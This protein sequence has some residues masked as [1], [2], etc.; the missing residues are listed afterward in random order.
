MTVQFRNI[1][2][3]AVT[4]VAFAWT[5]VAQAVPSFA[6]KHE[7]N[8]SACHA[9]Y[10]QLNATGR[11]Y[12]ENGYRFL[13][14]EEATDALE[15]SDSLQLEKHVPI[16]GILV[17]RPYDKKDSG[18]EKIRALHEVELIV[19]GNISENWSGYFEIEAEDETGFEP[20]LAPAVLTYNHSKELNVQ[21]VYGP[22]FWADPYGILGDHF[23]LTRGHVGAIDQRFGNADAGGR[24][25]AVR[26]NVG[27]YGR[28]SD[29][30]FYNVNFSGKAADA[31][32][33]NASVVSGLFNAEITDDIMVGVFTMNGDDEA[34]NRDFDRSGVQFQVDLTDLRIQGL[35]IAATDDRD[36]A[37]PRGPGEDDNNAFSLQ[38]FY[39]FRDDT[40]RP[41]WVP[42][43]RYDTYE[44]NDGVDSFDELTFNIGYYFNQN[45]KGYLEYW[46]RFDAPTALQEDSRITL[47]IV[48]AF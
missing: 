4:I 37:D 42:L 39:T 19:A 25:R 44:T 46:D 17:A 13:T 35:F 5:T 43:L 30:F 7:L 26:Q 15:V 12:K 8:C 27:L 41:T 34:T 21:F 45:I 33:E 23:R 11:E 10:P 6:R 2:I 16:S 36:A 28:V 14:A 32:G 48:A 3:P 20:E 31:E 40:L 38:S 22:T 24:F 9:A 18:N 1:L 29:R 47:Q